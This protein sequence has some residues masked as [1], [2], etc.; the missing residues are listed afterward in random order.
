M[1]AVA[2]GELVEAQAVPHIISQVVG[3]IVAAAILY[4]IASGKTGFDVGVTGLGQ[5]G[6]GPG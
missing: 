3:A 1:A 6:W 4:I 5:N 2:A